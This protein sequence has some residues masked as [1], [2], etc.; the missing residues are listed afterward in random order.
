MVKIFVIEQKIWDTKINWFFNM[1]MRKIIMKWTPY[2]KFDKISIVKIHL[3][4]IIRYIIAHRG[5]LFMASHIEWYYDLC[6]MC[7]FGIVIIYVVL[8]IGT[9][10][11][12]VCA[13][14]L[15]L[16]WFFTGFILVFRNFTRPDCCLVSDWT[17]QFGLVFK[18]LIIYIII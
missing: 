18:T 16:T 4:S 9:I 12:L 11:E 2:I 13:Q 10:K 17:D 15:G 3:C 8:K 14:I 7:P 1:I 6:I 5:N